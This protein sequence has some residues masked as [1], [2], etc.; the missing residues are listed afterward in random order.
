MKFITRI[1]NNR[2]ATFN[3]YSLNVSF[4]L[5]CCT[6]NHTKLLATEKLRNLQL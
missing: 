1:L 6:T 3:Y 2:T 4:I 5:E